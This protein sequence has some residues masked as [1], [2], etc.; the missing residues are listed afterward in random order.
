MQE[1]G[2]RVSVLRSSRTYHRSRI[3]LQIRFY[4]C[5]TPG[6]PIA[7][8]R[9][10]V[11]RW[12]A[13]DS[14]YIK[15]PL[16]SAYSCICRRLILLG[17][18]LR[19][20]DGM[21]R[22]GMLSFYGRRFFCFTIFLWRFTR[23]M[24]IAIFGLTIR[25]HAHLWRGYPEN[26]S[27]V[28]RVDTGQSVHSYSCTSYG[29][30]E[31]RTL[32]MLASSLKT[33]GA[34]WNRCNGFPRI[35]LLGMSSPAQWRWRWLSTRGEIRF[36]YPRGMWTPSS[37]SWT[38]LVRDMFSSWATMAEEPRKSLSIQEIEREGTGWFTPVHLS[39]PANRTR[40]R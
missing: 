32:Q 35:R 6:M 3:S 26:F 10:G 2:R 36:R 22:R 18:E 29:W 9:T 14:P 12:K 40:E 31:E 8:C 17:Q 25:S 13:G 20:F 15:G 4:L 23:V 33:H 27:A 39:F 37:A 7:P 28:R 1:C 19:K 5:C 11:E 24:R 30:W 16:R 34:L 21:A 38:G